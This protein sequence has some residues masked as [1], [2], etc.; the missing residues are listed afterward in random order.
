MKF[1]RHIN[2]KRFTIKLVILFLLIVLLIGFFFLSRPKDCGSGDS[3]FDS[4]FIKCNKAKANLV[5]QDGNTFNFEIKGKSSNNCIVDAKLLKMSDERPVDLR[6]AL[7]G[8]SMRC[9]IPSDVN[10]P[11]TQI[12]NLNDYC[13]GQLK[14]AM[15]QISIEKM[16]EI[17][18][19]NIGPLASE[20][21][22]VLKS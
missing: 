17:I 22:D 9:S 6:A 1:P 3:C 21:R 19:Q 18:V 8:K 10:I 11:I 15:L 14:E 13:T 5:N 2:K 7:E 12:D 4:S 20:F 16:Y